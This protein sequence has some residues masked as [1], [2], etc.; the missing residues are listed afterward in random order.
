M[1]ERMIEIQ[2]K[3]C[4]SIFALFRVG[5]VAKFLRVRYTI[6]EMSCYFYDSMTRD[7]DSD[8]VLCR[9]NS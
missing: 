7:S 1:V 8:I 9:E 4:E 2:I 5:T 6:D 3:F